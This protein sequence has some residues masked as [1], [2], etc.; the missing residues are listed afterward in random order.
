VTMFGSGSNAESASGD[1]TNNCPNTTRRKAKQRVIMASFNRERV[2]HA[3][4]EL[5]VRIVPEDVDDDEETADQRFNEAFGFAIDT[6][7]SA[8]DPPLVPDTD[9]IA[10]LID[11]RSK[12]TICAY[13]FRSC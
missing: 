11:D 3:L 10:D 13:N 8:G 4:N 6:L 2:E 9:H 1:P 5:I 12:S 7:S